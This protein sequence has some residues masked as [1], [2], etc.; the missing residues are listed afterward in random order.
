MLHRAIHDNWEWSSSGTLTN[1]SDC[2]GYYDLLSDY[3]CASS[4]A[5]SLMAFLKN[6]LK[7]IHIFWTK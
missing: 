7:L 3:K 5:L 6:I 1:Y 4:F 2:V